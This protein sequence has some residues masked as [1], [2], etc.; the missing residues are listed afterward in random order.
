[1]KKTSV[2]LSEDESRGLQ[3][4]AK[5]TGRSQAQLIRD[6]IHHVLRTTGSESRTFHSMGKGHGG[7]KPFVSW[8]ADELYA[9]VTGRE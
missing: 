7:G 1:M 5:V 4:A 6:A 9:S 8:D 3:H 2:Y